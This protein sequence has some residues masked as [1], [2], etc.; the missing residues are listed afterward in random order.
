MNWSYS[1]AHSPLPSNNFCIVTIYLH[2]TL[3][4]YH[5]IICILSVNE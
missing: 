5:L 2:F 4:L 3:Y 1:I